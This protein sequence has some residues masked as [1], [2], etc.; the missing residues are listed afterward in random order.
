MSEET[1]ENC[2]EESLSDATAGIIREINELG[3]DTSEVTDSDTSGNQSAVMMSASGCDSD[4]TMT[5]V[6]CVE[7]H[8]S[9]SSMPDRIIR[10]A[11]HAIGDYMSESEDSTSDT[12]MPDASSL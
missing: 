9:D 3:D 11:M 2:S 5:S 12:S 10:G 8:P 6:A 4:I 7:A 1:D